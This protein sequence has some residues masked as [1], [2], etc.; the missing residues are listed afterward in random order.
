MLFLKYYL[1]FAPHLL[2]GVVLIGFSRRKLLAHLP[3]FF[4]YLVFE[5]AQFL[6]LFATSRISPF[7]ITT[8]RWML[9]IGMGTSG[10]LILAVIYELANDLLLSRS[11]L[12]P[13]LRSVLRWT[14]ALLLFAAVLVSAALSRF[15]LGTA[16]SVFQALDFSASVVQCGLLIAMFLFRRAFH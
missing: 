8:Y 4:S 2:L 5:I 13:S 16:M 7:P 1:W 12:V 6:A 3:I 14:A 9:A 10:F 11:S 15:D